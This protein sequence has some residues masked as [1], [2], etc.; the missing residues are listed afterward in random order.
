MAQKL[1]TKVQDA[2][3]EAQGI[4]VRLNHQE[5]QAEHLLLAIFRQDDGIVPNVALSAGADVG[6]IISGVE[7]DLNQFPMVTGSNGGQVYASGRFNKFMI[8]A[9]D[10]ARKLK[11]EYVSTEHFLLAYF[12]SSFRDSA[13]HKALLQSGLTK[14]KVLHVLAK[15]RGNQRIQSDNPEATMNALEKFGKDLTD[16]AKKG[17]L[18]PVIGRDEE[19]RRVIQVLSRRTKNN[20][21]LIGEPGVGKTAIAEG[22]ARRISEGDVPETLKNKRVFTLDLGS[23]VAGAKFRGEFEE[24]LKAVLKAVTDS[25]GEIILFIDEMHTL[26]G[27]GKSDGAMDASNMLKPALAR[28]ELRCVGATTLN[29]YKKYIEKDAALERRFQ[30]VLVKE[31]SVEDTISI[32]RGLRERYEVHH[33]VSIKD[34]AIVAAA[35]L[36][37][38]YI[39][40]RFLPDKAIDL[41]DEA[42]SRVRMAID[43]MPENIDKLERRILQLEIERQALKK[44]TDQTSKTRLES[45]QKEL[46]QIKETSKSAKAVWQKEKLALTQVSELKSKIETTKHEME[47]AEKSG[48]LEKAAE[49]KYGALLNLQKQLDE[50]IAK[51]S[52]TQF[53][54]QNVDENTVAEVV[55]KWTGV[56]LTRMLEGEQQK[57]LLMEDRLKKRV[58][59]QEKGLVAVSDAIRRAR[60]G[61]QDP[62]RPIGSFLFLGP[63]GVGKTETAKALAEFLFDD[64]SSMIRVDMSEYMEKHSVSRLI[65]APPGYVGY[66]EGGQITEAVRRK[67]YC[68]LLF[69]EIEKAHP[70]VFNIFLQILDDGRCTDGQGRTVDFSNTV[71]IMTSNLGSKEIL[72]ESNEERRNATILALLRT[73]LKPEFINR[74]DEI[75][76]FNRLEKNQVESIVKIQLERLVRLVEAR[77]LHLDV[78]KDAVRWIANVGYD[79]DFGARPLK[80]VI[81]REV[82]NPLSKIILAG[83]HKAGD[84]IKIEIKNDHLSIV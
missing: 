71:L 38:R 44:E 81:Q 11:D 76:V 64:E 70:D 39:S 20:P 7:K 73:H 48:N 27:A 72:E 60:S 12:S 28:G 68:V 45:L 35:T 82:M 52:T 29:E 41:I 54:A 37:N 58:V 15:I 32:L 40:D 24:R 30:P 57:L 78:S 80:R 31:P 77:D 51:A 46:D 62:N 22:L 1:T 65:G 2:I 5:L 75:V 25:A 36:S 19:I 3:V 33:G 79:P 47:R 18:D 63:T 26:V 42:A 50:A 49:L 43:S 10:E 6:A 53:L 34:G 69:D 23:L 21:V 55:S 67:P 16:L 13:A 17:K 4:A 74:I 61:L 8:G 59:G 84:T 14:D 56:P 83:G 66:E 9:E